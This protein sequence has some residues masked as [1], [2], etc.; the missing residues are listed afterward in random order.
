L[1]EAVL[2]ASVAHCCDILMILVVN[3]VER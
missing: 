2:W 3:C 1:T